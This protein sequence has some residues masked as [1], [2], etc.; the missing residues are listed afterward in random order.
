M[1]DALRKTDN[2]TN[3]YGGINAAEDIALEHL[4]ND[5]FNDC[6]TNIWEDIMSNVST[7]KLDD[8]VAMLLFEYK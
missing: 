6:L 7:Q 1:S 3:I 4:V 8:D 5:E 2:K